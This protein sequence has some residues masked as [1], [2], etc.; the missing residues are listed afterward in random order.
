MGLKL[1]L[2]AFW[3]PKYFLSRE[4]DKVKYSTISALRELAEAYVPSEKLG[5]TREKEPT[6]SLESRRRMMA[7]EHEALVNTLIAAIGR[8]KT[9]TV[10]RKVMFEVGKKLG[11]DIRDRLGMGKNLQDLVKAAKILYLVLGINFCV[12]WKNQTNAVLVVNRCT[13][14]NEYSDTTC[15]V[16]SATDEGV[17]KGLNEN[18]QMQFEDRIPKGCST[19]T[20]CVKLKPK[21]GQLN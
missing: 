19:C 6:G 7:K 3:T 15:L 21:G 17:V 2:L 13:L 5:S 10:G 4:L 9:V 1:D 11:E 14:A 16:L 12:E 18:V 20:A 8:D